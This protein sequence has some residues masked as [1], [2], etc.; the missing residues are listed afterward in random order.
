MDIHH[1]TKWR[2][3]RKAILA[4]DHYRC[5]ECKKYGRLTEAVLV[6]HI[7]AL[8]DYPELAFDSDNL[9]SLCYACHAA[10]HPEKGT[11][12]LKSQRWNNGRLGK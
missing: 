8:E 1:T 2:N 4:R 11:K 6:H 5:V 10:M 7:K 9:V 3:K 12:G